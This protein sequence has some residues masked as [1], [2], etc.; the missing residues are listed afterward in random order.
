MRVRVAMISGF[1]DCMFL[2]YPVIH[3]SSKRKR[4]EKEKKNGNKYS[5]AGSDKLCALPKY[6]RTNTHTSIYECIENCLMIGL[7]WLVCDVRE[8]CLPVQSALLSRFSVSIPFP[9]IFVCQPEPI[10]YDLVLLHARAESFDPK[11]SAP[12]ASIRFIFM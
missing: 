1:T 4:E 10:P 9:L 6:P 11:P 2:T 12:S 5:G 3:F 7:A 8:R